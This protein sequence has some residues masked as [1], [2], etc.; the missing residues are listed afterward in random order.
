MMLTMGDSTEQSNNWISFD[1]VNSDVTRT[2]HQWM[3]AQPVSQSSSSGCP[4]QYARRELINSGDSGSECRCLHPKHYCNGGDDDTNLMSVAQNNWCGNV[5]RDSAEHF[6][7]LN[8][9][10]FTAMT[11]IFIP[12]FCFA[13]SRQDASSQ[14]NNGNVCVNMFRVERNR[15][16]DWNSFPTSDGNYIGYNEGS[17]GSRSATGAWWV[18]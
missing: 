9:Q 12:A 11:W 18:R 5:R 1:S 2:A 16:S 6:S 4:Y 15:Q 7:R 8:A 3:A 17:S 14:V 10:L 13:I